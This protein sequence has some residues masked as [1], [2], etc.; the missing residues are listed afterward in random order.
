MRAGLTGFLSVFGAADLDLSAGALETFESADVSN[1]D[2]CRLTDT[3]AVLVYTDVGN[4]NYGTAVVLSLSGTTVTAGTPVVYKSVGI[5]SKNRVVRVDD[6]HVIVG[7]ADSTN[8]KTFAQCLTISGTTITTNTEL[9]VNNG[10]SALIGLMSFDSTYFAIGYR[11]PNGST[12]NMPI[13]SLL[14][15]SG[16]TLTEEDTANIHIGASAQ[17]SIDMDGFSSTLGIVLYRRSGVTYARQVSRSGATITTLDADTISSDL[18][19]QLCVSALDSTRAIVCGYWTGTGNTRTRGLIMEIS[20]SV[21]TNGTIT[22]IWDQGNFTHSYV[23]VA[24]YDS[25][26]AV[27]CIK[28]HDD[29]ATYNGG[30]AVGV[31]VSVSGSTI[32]ADSPVIV[33]SDYA[34]THIANCAL[35]STH[36]IVGF[37]SSNGPAGKAACLYLS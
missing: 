26:N 37:R 14:S 27:V 20:G 2:V 25:S 22:D 5:N 12:A 6:T 29:A 1:L 4:S 28:A 36:G 16:T 35:T 7:Y 18:S 11:D 8:S 17:D 32:T 13:C 34:G 10:Y 30:P 31:H 15:L 19:A 24:A 23:D 9:E 3:K 33:E 21:F